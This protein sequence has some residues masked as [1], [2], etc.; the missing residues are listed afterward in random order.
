VG[1][2]NDE[3]NDLSADLVFAS[4]PKLARREHL[5]QLRSERFDYV[6][7][8]EVHHAAADSCRRI[9]DVLDPRFL[10]GP[11]ATPDRA[12]TGDILGLFDDF[13][14]YKADIA[15]GVALRDQTGGSAGVV[16]FRYFGIKDDID[17]STSHG[18]TDAST[19]RRSRPRPR[20]NPGDSGRAMLAPTRTMPRTR[21]P[22]RLRADL[23]I[24]PRGGGGALV[25]DRYEVR[26]PAV[27]DAEQTAM[28]FAIGAHGATEA[29]RRQLREKAG[30]A[31]PIST[32]RSFAEE[33]VENAILEGPAARRDRETAR[34]RAQAGGEWVLFGNPGLRVLAETLLEKAA[35]E[36]EPGGVLEGA[37]S[38]HGA[39]ENTGAIAARIYAHLTRETWPDLFVIIGTAHYGTPPALLDADLRLPLGRVLNDRDAAD[40]LCLELGRGLARNP[41][42]F[43]IEHS[44]R[45]DLPLLQIVAERLDRPLRVLPVLA[46][47][48]SHAQARR[49]GRAIAKV[50]FAQCKRVC[51][52]A[53]GDLTHHGAGYRWSPPW[54]R[55]D[56]AERCHAIREFERPLLEAIVRGDGRTFA[57][58]V[59]ATSFC[60]RAQVS[61]LLE[62]V[63]GEGELLGHQ[64]VL[65]WEP[66][67][68]PPSRAWQESDALFNGAAIAFRFGRA[69]G[70]CSNVL[71]RR[72]KGR[73]ALLH[74][75][76]LSPWSM[77]ANELGV[78]REVARGGAP[79]EIAARLGGLEPE[80]VRGFI[81]Q[82]GEGGLLHPAATPSNGPAP[83]VIARAE[84][85]IAYARRA[86]PFYAGLR[87]DRLA[88]APLLFSDS[89][90]ARWDELFARGVSR[91]G[92][93][94][95]RSS[96]SSGPELVSVVEHPVHEERALAEL[97]VRS[98]L[99]KGR[100]ARV[101]RPR[102]LGLSPGPRGWP[103]IRRDE[104]VLAITPGPN[105][106]EVPAEVWTRTLAA[107]AEFDPH[108]L[109]GEPAYL[110]E[111]ARH[112]M[113]AGVRL[114]PARLLLGHSFAWSLHREALRRAFPAAEQVDLYHS[115]E[116]GEIALG[117]SE[118][119]LHL[120]EAR[121]AFELLHRGR[122]VA[123]GGCGELVAT[124]LDTRLR[125]LIRYVTGDVVELTGTECP[126]GRPF[127]TVRYRG[128][129]R[130][131]IEGARGFI[132]YTEIDEA[133]GAA[134]GVRFFRLAVRDRR[135]RL[136]LVGDRA[137]VERGLLRDRLEALLRRPVT[138]AF[139]SRL[140]IVDGGKLLAVDAPDRSAQWHARF[141]APRS[142]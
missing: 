12:D 99:R 98:D 109:E 6:V 35:A 138:L 89:I 29:A 23:R 108:V 118:G 65:N 40:A 127:R 142:K 140:E 114:A 1:W 22:H 92:H 123:P 116:L 103:A 3:A 136:E 57:A 141:L 18:A 44:F 31:P 19:R 52:I 42:D 7:V 51:V 81:G 56:V 24:L 110:A 48:L 64:S 102:N 49:L 62:C 124:T 27:L 54:L 36:V 90:R 95:R 8:D 79:E 105:P 135:A 26:S 28:A 58:G 133:I 59:E 34:A 87:S 134:T 120:L 131:L 115:S 129:A 68:K 25:I 47:D 15:R 43:L 77:E 91:D 137:L 130:H 60:A 5:E 76:D 128:R 20:P 45:Q 104:A 101:N 78:L 41:P 63:Q 73:T 39:L 10:L 100:I 69:R 84:Q 125:P 13:T 70:L 38:P 113:A 122:P 94:V 111:L 4:V 46:G 126:C 17:T 121:I 71:V 2:F 86:V 88:D 96:A 30:F 37:L 16:P 11:T 66:I 82:L 32:L 67:T 93:Y 14:A 33:L 107:I 74:R 72:R 112:A 75:C 106:T 139:T 61:A 21:E 50:L 55:G 85:T 132:G 80:D 117:C 83:E 9:L 119:R 53:S 97:L